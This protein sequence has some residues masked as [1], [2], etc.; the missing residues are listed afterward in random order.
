M[1]A[2]ERVVVLFE[3]AEKLA[4]QA[5]AA[6]AKVSMGEFIKRA[7]TDWQVAPTAEQSAELEALAAEL[8][9]AAG[10]MTA[11]LDATI[12]RLDR[13]LDPAREAEQR[14]RIEAEVAELD[15]SGVATALGL[16]A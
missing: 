14:R 13:V 15:L 16:A 12:A 4:L 8:E 7:V 1:A 10:T 5:R 3:P 11:K 2:T 9:R 6:A